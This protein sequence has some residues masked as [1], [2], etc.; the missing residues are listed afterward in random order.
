MLRSKQLATCAALVTFTALGLTAQADSL[1]WDGGS[2]VDSFFG[3]AA[4]WDNLGA[5]QAPTA[6]DDLFFDARASVPPRTPLWEASDAAQSIAVDNSGG[7]VWQFARNGSVSA[8]SVTIGSGGLSVTGGGQTDWSAVTTSVNGAQN[9]TVGAGTTLNFA[10]GATIGG[11]GKITKLGTGTLILPNASNTNIGGWDVMAGVLVN[12][13]STQ[14]AGAAGSLVSVFS[15]AVYESRN[16]IGSANIKLYDGS[17]LRG[18]GIGVG[19]ASGVSLTVDTAADSSV[20]LSTV[21]ANDTFAITPAVIGG[22]ANSLVTISGPGLVQ[23]SNGSSNATSAGTYA[24]SWRVSSGKLRLG[25]INSLGVLGGTPRPIELAGGTVVYAAGPNSAYV[26]AASAVNVT[27]DSGMFI[28]R[29][30][31]ANT[32]NTTRTAAGPLTVNGSTITFRNGTQGM[33]GA[34]TATLALGAVTLTGNATFD[35]ANGLS[36]DSQLVQLVVNMSGVGQSSAGKGITKSGNGRLNLNAVN[37]YT[38]ATS[39]TGGTLQ[40]SNTGGLTTSSINVA[41]GASVQMNN[42]AASQ[43]WTTKADLSGAGTIQMFNATQTLALQGSSISP[44]DSAGILSITGG[45]VSLGL[46]GAELS[47]LTI[48]VTGTGG[49]AGTDHDRLEVAS[50]LLGLASTDLIIDLSSL[51]LAGNDLI[52]QTLIIVTANT[53]F[54]SVAFASETFSPGWTGDVNYNN[55]NITLTNLVGPIP[56][57]ASLALMGLGGL[58]LCWRRSR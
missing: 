19:V 4:N 16:N 32:G 41:A 25:D 58:M 1:H 26:F 33:N 11:N 48:E 5:D 28:E 10:S 53:N 51:G 56:E 30:V 36:A 57:P 3:T 27:A 7:F 6:G 55:G 34:Q 2:G 15:N 8:R 22:T 39:V 20:T 18:N 43:T 12:P 49:V 37:T 14:G 40:F 46:D 24:G 31:T 38:G 47:A 35:I 13:R 9:W 45:A 21:G 42:G 54:T 50:A 29:G 44:G 17:T 23:L 52:G